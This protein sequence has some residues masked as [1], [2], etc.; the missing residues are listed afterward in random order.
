MAKKSIP[1]SAS[2]AVE[3]CDAIGDRLL[4][5]AAIVDLLGCEKSVRN[6]PA[7]DTPGNAAW[8]ART[9]IDE[10]RAMATELLE[11]AKQVRS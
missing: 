2:S 4:K 11:I 6:P 8:A 9:M 3:L 1:A 5:A 7:D 10:A